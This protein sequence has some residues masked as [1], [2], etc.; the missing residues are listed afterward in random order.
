MACVSYGLNT[1]LKV[2]YSSHDLNIGLL[3]GI[4]T[5]GKSKFRVQTQNKYQNMHCDITYL[6][7]LH[8]GSNPHILSY[9]LHYFATWKPYPCRLFLS[10]RIQVP[11]FWKKYW[12]SPMSY[13][14]YLVFPFKKSG[15]RDNFESRPW[16]L[17]ALNACCASLLV[18]RKVCHSAYHYSDAHCGVYLTFASLILTW[19]LGVTKVGTFIL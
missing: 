4:W 17:S 19:N 5:G 8:L 12:D 18:F 7:T 10:L 16:W 2:H 15:I 14:Y 13:F 6:M 1:K 9:C 11:D 3:Q